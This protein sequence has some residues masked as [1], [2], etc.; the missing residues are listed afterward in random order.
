MFSS[1]LREHWRGRGDHDRVCKGGG[2]R[3]ESFARGDQE[4]IQR[5]DLEGGGGGGGGG[6]GGGVGSRG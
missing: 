6:W 1:D 3:S 4:G 2:G 5:H